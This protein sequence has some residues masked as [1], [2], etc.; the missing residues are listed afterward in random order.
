[1]TGCSDFCEVSI[2]FCVQAHVCLSRIFEGSAAAHVF[3]WLS[4]ANALSNSW[5]VSCKELRTWTSFSFALASAADCDCAEFEAAEP[6]P[7]EE[8]EHAVIENAASKDAA[9]AAALR[10]N[11]RDVRMSAVPPA[12]YN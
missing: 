4:V 1:V 5:V 7:E 2:M 12:D 8:L 10:E 6:L 3:H 11:R 9:P